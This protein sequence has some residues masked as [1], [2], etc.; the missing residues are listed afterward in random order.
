MFFRAFSYRTARFRVVSDAL[1]GSGRGGLVHQGRDVLREHLGCH[2]FNP[3]RRLPHHV[4]GPSASRGF[5]PDA[6]DSGGL[7][8]LSSLLWTSFR[9]FYHVLPSFG[10]AFRVSK[11]FKMTFREIECTQAPCGQCNRPLRYWILVHCILQLLQAPVRLVFFLRLCR[12]QSLNN[13]I[14]E[15]FRGLNDLKYHLKRLRVAVRS[16]CD[17]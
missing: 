9:L 4:L 12:V 16:V 6:S 15:R 5:R 7:T 2:Y 13:N 17:S 10:P 1:G 3:L 11:A 8:A 14:Q